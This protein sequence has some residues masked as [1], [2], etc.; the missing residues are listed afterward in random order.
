LNQLVT[1][2]DGSHTIYVPELNEHY[3]SIHG[4]IQESTFIFINNGFDTCNADP[5]YIFEVGF[6][7]GLNALLTAMKNRS[8]K[9]EVFYNSIEK[10]PL[11]KETIRSLNYHYFVGKEGKDIF[12]SIHSSDWDI[13]TDIIK[14]FNLRKIKGDL[15]EERLTG[16]Y[17]LIY[18]DAFGPDKQPEM[19]TKEIFD[20]IAAVTNKNGILV[21]YSAKGEVK[22]NLKSCGF[23]VTLLPGPPGKRQIIRAV[24]K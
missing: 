5:M 13:G 16:K 4:A 19:W 18:F 20:S 14:N 6:G 11:D 3:H 1:T 10:F 23:E 2:S 24:K 15:T 21:T 22:R 7:T 9:R 17:D 12:S 8:C